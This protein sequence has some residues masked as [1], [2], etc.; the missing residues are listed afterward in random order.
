MLTGEIAPPRRPKAVPRPSVP[1]P[2]VVAA[3]EDPA[4]QAEAKAI[5]GYAESVLW[6]VDGRLALDWL[7]RRGLEDRTIRKFRLGF[8]PEPLRTPSLEILPFRDGRPQSAWLPRGVVI[9]WLRPG[10]W[11]ESRDLGDGADPGP[12]WVGLNCRRLAD[13]VD[14][15]LLEGPKYSTLT[16]STRGYAYPW[17]TL[18][19]SQG[20]P[21]AMILEGEFDALLAEQAVGHLVYATTTG[22]A[23]QTPHLSALE[24]LGYCPWWLVATDHDDRGDEAAMAWFERDR[25]KYRRLYLP[26]GKDLSEYVVAGGDVC[27]WLR[28]EADQIRAAMRT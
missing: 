13:D 26:H 16:G 20:H 1:K 7:R 21:P 3:W 4:W 14:G 11:Y 19:A 12:R 5:V 10:S 25:D 9:P 15:P 24:A 17:P 22:G 18:D 2:R 28:S 6:S 23:Q 27:A 8:T